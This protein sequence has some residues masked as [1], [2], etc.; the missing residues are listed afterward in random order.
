MS[1]QQEPREAVS[2]LGLRAPVG[3]PTSGGS[4]VAAGLWAPGRG[5]GGWGQGWRDLE[6]I[7]PS[8]GT[9]CK[10]C[11]VASGRKALYKY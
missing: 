6:Y 11:W 9:A 3:S 1:S 2:V 10:L 5:E 8:A 7:A 4:G